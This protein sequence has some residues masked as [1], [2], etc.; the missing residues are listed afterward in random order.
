PP[1]TASCGRW[2]AWSSWRAGNEVFAPARLSGRTDHGHLRQLEGRLRRRRHAVRPPRAADRHPP[3][4][5][6][7]GASDD[8]LPLG[9]LVSAQ[10]PR[11]PK[12][13]DLRVSSGTLDRAV[14]AEAIDAQ[15]EER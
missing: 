12:L 14:L 8:R 15:R 9:R 6:R 2:R 4:L 5:A 11:T 10:A 7:R 1:R 13:G 3:A